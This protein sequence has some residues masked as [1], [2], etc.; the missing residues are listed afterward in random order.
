[1]ERSS[2]TSK[3]I[4]GRK[5]YTGGDTTASKDSA[6]KKAKDEGKPKERKQQ[7]PGATKYLVGIIFVVLIIGIAIFA[8]SLL[9]TKPSP[10]GS[11][12]LFKKNF[13]SASR[14]DIFVEDPNS[15]VY[16]STFGCASAVIIQ[17]IANQTNH[18]NSSTIDFNVI[19]QTSCIRSSGLGGSTS[20]YITTSLQNCLNTS[21]T[22]PALFINYSGTNS[23][24]I[25]PEDM[26]VSG[27][28]L[29]LR[30]CGIASEIS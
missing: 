2:E 11:F 24:I 3:R 7:G 6:P 28:L 4:H 22:E 26:Y 13:D 16:Q 21:R 14:V 17:I 20:N 23:T 19:N 10:S 27:T 9:T 18:R 25:G 30:E 5:A 29:F 15:T 12:Q 8:N 1:M